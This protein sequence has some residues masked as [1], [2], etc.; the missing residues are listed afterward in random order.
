MLIDEVYKTCL[1]FANVSQVGGYL[2]PSNFNI[3]CALSQIQI[4]NELSEIAD[5]NQRVISLSSDVLKTADVNVID[6]NTNLPDDYFIYL[7]ANALFYDG[8][9]ERFEEY[10]LDYI[11]KSE[12]GERL[13]SK[14]V[15]PQNDYP[16]VTESVGGLK[17]EPKEVNRIRLTYFTNPTTP[18]WVG[19]NTVPP[20]F[21]P[22]ASTDFTLGDKFKNILVYK[23]LSYFS[24]EI[25]EPYLLQA[26]TKNL[27]QFTGNKT[28]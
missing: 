22:N 5:Y 1:Q 17:V 15:D 20:V 11:G 3:S 18:E 21:D 25:R 13:R 8:D 2:S 19:T 27:V 23:I 7:D 4:I 12:R 24:I 14:I 28:N 10:P 26:T 6:G 9:K 16:I